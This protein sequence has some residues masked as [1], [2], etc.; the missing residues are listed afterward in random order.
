VF[1]GNAALDNQLYHSVFL[2]YYKFSMFRGLNLN[3]STSFNKRLKTFKY[4]TQLQ[5]IEQY[6]S[7]VLLDQSEH[8]WNLNGMISKKIRKIRYNLSASFVYNDFYQILNN[9]TRLNISK[10]T[11]TTVSA[12]TSFKNWPNIEVGYTKDFSNYRSSNTV[13]RFQNDLL[14]V[15]L[16]YDFLNDFIFKTDYNFDSYT[17]KTTELTNTFEIANASLFYQ[18]EDSPWGF[19]VEANNIFDVG[20]KQQNSFN[21]FLISDRKTFVMPRMI[22]FKVSYKL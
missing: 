10:T 1:K 14:F 21:S 6:S 22:M 2:S 11:S 15:E 9:D 4:E 7:P 8:N 18:K 19:E 5:G 13:T 3:F 16:Q 12:E 20:F 17:N